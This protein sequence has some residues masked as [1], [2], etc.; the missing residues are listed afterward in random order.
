MTADV[1]T[2]HM[3][4][5]LQKDLTV[6]LMPPCGDDFH[7]TP[8]TGNISNRSTVEILGNWEVGA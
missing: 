7:C 4:A 3:C 5:N 6:K 8:C 2:V 1:H